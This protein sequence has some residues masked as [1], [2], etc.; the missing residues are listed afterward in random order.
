MI[1]GR[2]LAW[3]SRGGH[4]VATFLAR[5]EP[6]WTQDAERLARA[7]IDLSSAP[8]S[9]G[10]RT[11]MLASI[12]GVPAPESPLAAVLVAHGFVSRQ[13]SLVYIPSASD[14]TGRRPLGRRGSTW[15][16]EED[17]GIAFD[18]PMIA[19]DVELDDEDED[20]GI[21]GEVHPDA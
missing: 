3:L 20:P 14:G 18:F 21:D 16:R 9:H 5:E 13:G 7:L 19:S 6:G 1:E 15:S 10:H 11:T 4:H 17:I 2:L 12:D 8:R